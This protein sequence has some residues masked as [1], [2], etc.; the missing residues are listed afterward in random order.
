MVDGSEQF[1]ALVSSDNE[2]FN[3]ERGVANVSGLVANVLEDVSEEETTIPIPNVESA[4]LAKVIEY[5]RYHYH[6]QSNPQSDEDIDKW[7]KEFVRVDKPTLFHLIL[8]ANYMD[9]QSLLDLT[10]KSVADMIKGK[11]AE[12]IRGEFGIVNDFT[13]E[14]EEEIRRENAWV[15]DR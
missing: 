10:C 4:I 8:A 7:N 2:T 14:E 13:P 9:I 11:S 1:V 6:L 3:V 15:E 12:Q 5:C